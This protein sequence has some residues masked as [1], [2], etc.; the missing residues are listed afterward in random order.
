MSSA[1]GTGGAAASHG[2]HATAADREIITDFSHDKI[3]MCKLALEGARLKLGRAQSRHEEN[4]DDDTQR[5]L[6]D[7]HAEVVGIEDDLQMLEGDLRI[8]MS[9][10]SS[11]QSSRGNNG[12]AA[13][14][15]AGTGAAVGNE[16]VADSPA[17]DMKAR[18]KE[19]TFLTNEKERLKGVIED[20]ITKAETE[21]DKKRVKERAITEKRRQLLRKDSQEEDLERDDVNG[22]TQT[23]DFEDHGKNVCATYAL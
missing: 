17:D 10:S 1:D 2:S 19:I 4:P 12:A 5:E 16:P 23:S 8:H 3:D 20:C 6:S 7:V 14:A 11:A 15:T 18:D 13:A 9:S 22:E 21:R